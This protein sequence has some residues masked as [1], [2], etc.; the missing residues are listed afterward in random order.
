MTQALSAKRIATAPRRGLSMIEAAAYIGVGTTKFYD[1]VTAGEMPLPR[2]I[3]TRKV[4]DIRDLDR[5]FDE[6]A[7]D[8]TAE[9]GSWADR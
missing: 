8:G 2:L 3:G 4:W 7:H 6:L 1:M 5:A 9:G